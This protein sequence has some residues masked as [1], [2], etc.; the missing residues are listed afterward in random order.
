MSVWSQNVASLGVR[1]K[2]WRHEYRNP[3]VMVPCALRA[4]YLPMNPVC[5]SLVVPE[6]V[7]IWPSRRASTLRASTLS[8]VQPREGTLSA[9]DANAASTP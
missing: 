1:E 3:S 8:S 7:T 9:G 2:R 5:A 4:K 6:L